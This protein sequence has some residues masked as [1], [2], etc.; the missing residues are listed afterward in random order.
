M[1][2][3]LGRQELEHPG[4]ECLRRHGVAAL[5]RA[6]GA[7]EQAI[8]RLPADLGRRVVERAEL[9]AVAV[10]LL[11]VVADDL[12][13]LH[14]VGAELGEPGSEALVQLGARGLRER[15]VRRVADQ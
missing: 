15:F 6:V 12:V 3:A 9:D 13:E 10:G 4:E 11:E 1:R 7:C 14:E 8:C 2:L 5:P